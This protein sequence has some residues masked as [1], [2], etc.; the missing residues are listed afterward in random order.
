MSLLELRIALTKDRIKQCKK[1]YRI[2][3][4]FFVFMIAVVIFDCYEIHNGL[5]NSGILIGL[6]L[7]LANILWYLS[8]LYNFGSE[9]KSET[10]SLEYL[11]GMVL[12]QE[13]VDVLQMLKQSERL[14]AGATEQINDLLRRQA[15][16]SRE[17]TQQESVLPEAEKT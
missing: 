10:R 17:S 2:L 3:T 1:Y 16:V 6:G 14:H 15:N 8:D 12:Q 9:I 4:G 11:E 13:Y 5:S 7:I